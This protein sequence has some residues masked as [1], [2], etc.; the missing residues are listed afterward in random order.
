MSQKQLVN[1]DIVISITAAVAKF[2]FWRKVHHAQNRLSPPIFIR[3]FICRLCMHVY[4]VFA[5]C[6]TVSVCQRFL[7]FKFPY[8]FY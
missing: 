3:A 6:I 5:L 4:V 2:N 8:K 7:L 1:S